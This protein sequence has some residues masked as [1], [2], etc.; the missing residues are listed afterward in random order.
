MK[1]RI[2]STL[3]CTSMTSAIIE[4]EGLMKLSHLWQDYTPF[5]NFQIHYPPSGRLQ[6]GELV[7]YSYTE[8][9]LFFLKLRCHS[10]CQQ[11]RQIF[12]LLQAE[13]QRKNKWNP[14]SRPMISKE[15]KDKYLPNQ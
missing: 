13:N 4:R 6:A 2:N 11:K 1:D 10:S 9:E 5:Q 14:S 7:A 12:L 3:G 8:L 15:V